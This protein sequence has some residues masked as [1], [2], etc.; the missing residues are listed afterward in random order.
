MDSKKIL[1]IRYSKRAKKEYIELLDYLIED[2]GKIVAEKVDTIIFNT[3]KQITINPTQYPES[4]ERK[5]IRRCVL[6]KQTTIYYR[7]RHNYIE[8]VTFWA[9]RKNPLKKRI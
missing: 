9:N 5:G 1:K 4:K 8:V 7:V 6:S 3:L 2:F